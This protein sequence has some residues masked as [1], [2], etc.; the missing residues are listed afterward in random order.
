MSRVYRDPRLN[1]EDQAQG[2]T[3]QEVRHASSSALS[4]LKRS[5]DHVDEEDAALASLRK[6]MA[7]REYIK[8][9]GLSS[10]QLTPPPC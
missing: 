7:G 4:S 6:R 5:I 1:S 10:Y 9:L 8:Y 2:A 3:V